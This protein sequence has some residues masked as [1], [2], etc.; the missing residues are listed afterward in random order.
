[1][2]LALA[3]TLMVA[4]L[5]LPQG[6]QAL[7]A[8]AKLEGKNTKCEAV[9]GGLMKVIFRAGKSGQIERIDI[10]TPD[11]H[12]PL[13]VVARETITDAQDEKFLFPLTAA[14]AKTNEL[15]RPLRTYTAYNYRGAVDTFVWGAKDKKTGQMW[16]KIVHQRA[17]QVDYIPFHKCAVTK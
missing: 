6:A 5:T 3:S 16:G 2:T 10:D 14:E 8:P 17:G 13:K 15:V 11:W 4:T 12:N 9:L 7:A 1:M